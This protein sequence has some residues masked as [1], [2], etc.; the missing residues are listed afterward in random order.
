MTMPPAGQLDIESHPALLSYLRD[1][2]H[3]HPQ[4]QPRMQTLAGGV[5]NRTVLVE[6]GDG[7][8][9]VLKQALAKLRVAVDWFSDPARIERE[10]AGLRAFGELAAGSVPALVFEDRAHHLLAMESVPQ[11][12]ENYKAVLLAGRVDDDHVAQFAT[13]LG[14]IHRESW[15][16]RDRYAAAFDDRSF[17]ETLRV[18]PYYRYS[19]AQTPEA[20]AFIDRLIDQ[21]NRRRLAIVHGDYSPKNVLIHQGRLVLLDFEVIHFGDP[22][23]DV[24]FA[25]T[26]YLSKAHHLPMHR[27]ALLKAARLFW[28]TY[29][30]TLSDVPWRDEHESMCVA[31]TLGCMLA[32]VRGRST[33]EYLDEDER[34][35][36]CGIVLA[37][38]RALPN[39]LDELVTLYAGLLNKHGAD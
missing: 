17:F 1:N 11:P 9:W 2:G 10:A 23:F 29:Q 16:A 18:E 26:H 8:A 15:L 22:A 21:T 36:Q 30:E 4:A 13:L 12:H 27:E 31:H 28:Q 20:Q 5:S 24:G 34:D 39:T 19:A 7:R 37:V 6:L 14:R 25:L 32:R 38:M 35:R 3:I 33:L